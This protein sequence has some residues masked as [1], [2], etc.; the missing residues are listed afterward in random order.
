[1]GPLTAQGR[2]RDCAAVLEAR[3]PVATIT[4]LTNLEPTQVGRPR[5]DE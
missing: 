5:P 4:K 2:I 1:M 3:L